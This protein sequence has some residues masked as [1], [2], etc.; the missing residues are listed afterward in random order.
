MIAY[1]GGLLR[2]NDLLRTWI[3]H[4]FLCASH[5]P[6]VISHHVARDRLITFEPVE[7]APDIL[8]ELLT[9]YWSGLSRPIH[10]FPQSSWKFVL[11]KKSPDHS[12]Q[13]CLSAAREAW[14]GGYAHGAEKENSYNRICF[15]GVDPLDDEF[16]SLSENVFMPLMAHERQE[17]L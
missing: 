10:F 8:A 12:R 1:R 3:M 16:V 7:H 14:N 5:D 9:I 13:D 15:T 11:E 4:L 2:G 17:K 6:R